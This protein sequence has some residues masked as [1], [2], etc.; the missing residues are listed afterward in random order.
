MPRD[1]EDEMDFMEPQSTRDPL[2]RML[3]HAETFDW[4]AKAYRQRRFQSEDGDDRYSFEQMVRFMDKA[5][6]RD[7]EAMK[8]MCARPD[9][10]SAGNVDARMI[11]LRQRQLMRKNP[12]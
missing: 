11:R 7:K 8:V 5:F 1:G 10:V 3:D 6:E 9:K 12:L 2:Q 4:I